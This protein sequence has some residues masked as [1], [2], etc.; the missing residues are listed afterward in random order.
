MERR[1]LV[2]QSLEIILDSDRKTEDTDQ[3]N[4]SAFKL[5]WTY[6]CDGRYLGPN[7]CLSF[8]KNSNLGNIIE[9]KVL[10]LPL[11][12]L[13]PHSPQRPHHEA[14]RGRLDQNQAVFRLLQMR[15][16]EIQIFIIGCQTTFD[17][18]PRT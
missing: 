9:S 10:N 3:C 2:Y 16:V 11:T 14:Q 8:T 12:N 7:P 13:R 4:V 18:P 15:Q 1:K 6:V 5:S 17:S